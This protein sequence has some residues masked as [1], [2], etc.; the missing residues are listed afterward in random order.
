M[1]T[2]DLVEVTKED[3]FWYVNKHRLHSMDGGDHMNWFQLPPGAP[4][5]A[6]PGSLTGRSTPGRFILPKPGQHKPRYYL[7]RHAYAECPE[8]KES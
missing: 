1:T 8:R 3:F 5:H 7:T 6:F 2:D 4:I